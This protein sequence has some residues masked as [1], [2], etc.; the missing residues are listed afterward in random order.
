MG[1]ADVKCPECGAMNYSLYLEETGG[2]ME[3]EHC[4]CTVHLR[5]EKTYTQERKE[6][7]RWQIAKIWPVSRMAV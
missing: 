3:C 7:I 5:R 6:I 2:L 4:G 1:T